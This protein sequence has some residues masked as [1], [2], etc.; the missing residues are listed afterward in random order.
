[1]Y[2]PVSASSTFPKWLF[3]SLDS[4]AP[5][6]TDFVLTSNE[7]ELIVNLSVSSIR[8]PPRFDVFSLHEAAKS[9][10]KQQINK[11]F[12][13]IVLFLFNVFD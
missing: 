7:S 5:D 1:M 12:K 6:K 10:P 9:M 3:T 11:Y 4:T 8:L 13:R 2:V